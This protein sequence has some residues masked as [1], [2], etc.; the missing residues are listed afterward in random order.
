M[1]DLGWECPTSCGDCCYAP[2]ISACEPLKNGWCKHWSLIGCKLPR[3]KRPQA[4]NVYLCPEVAE[5]TE[6]VS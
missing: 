6:G 5:N 2:G 1:P 4:C 3:E